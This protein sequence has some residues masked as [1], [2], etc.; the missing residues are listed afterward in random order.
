MA[1]TAQ[2]TTHKS[3]DKSSNKPS[4]QIHHGRTWAAWVGS[5]VALIATI[6][7]GVGVMMQNWPVFWVGVALLIAALIATKVLQKMGY[8]AD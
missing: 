4:K 1:E 3:S 8:G 7:G 5:I 2:D 6:I